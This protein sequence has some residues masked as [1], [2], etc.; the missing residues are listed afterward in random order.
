MNDEELKIYNDLF[1][2]VS[3]VMNWDE[4]KTDTWFWTENPHL[5]NVTP[6]YLM[7]NGRSWKLKKFVESHLEGAFE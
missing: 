3:K 4:K 5:G 7:N 6:M 1:E 2:R